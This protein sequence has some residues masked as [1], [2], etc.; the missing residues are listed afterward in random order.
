M[1]YFILN[2]DLL[3]LYYI[4]IFLFCLLVKLVLDLASLMAR[5]IQMRDKINLPLGFL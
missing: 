4:C 2:V 5:I 1:F 3:A